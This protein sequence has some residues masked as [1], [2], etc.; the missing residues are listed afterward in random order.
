MALVR[1]SRN[2]LPDPFA[3]FDRLQEQMGQ[4]FGLMNSG[5]SGLFDRN[6]S[7][8]IDVLDEGE[9]VSVICNLPGIGHKDIE[10]SITNNVLS[11]K[12][13]R[14][15]AVEKRKM[16]KDESWT[17]TFQRTIS[18]PPVIDSDKI[19]AELAEGVLRI[20]LDKKP[21]S[22]PRQISVSVK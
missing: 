3:E 12:G 10:L 11:I 2:N 13:E 15:A 16:F 14:K 22:K 9:K 20:R 5:Q 8:A 18:L 1:W 19:M 21:E 17:G 6:S 4:L 7:P